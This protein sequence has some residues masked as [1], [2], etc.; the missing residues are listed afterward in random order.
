MDDIER[1]NK[2]R[3]CVQVMVEDLF[4]EEFALWQAR[5]VTSRMTASKGSIFVL[6]KMSADMRPM[7]VDAFEVIDIDLTTM[8]GLRVWVESK[9]FAR[10]GYAITHKPSQLAGDQEVFAWVPF[11]PNV[12]YMPHPGGKGWVLRAEICA[13]TRSRSQDPVAGD[14]YLSPVGEFRARFRAFAEVRF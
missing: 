11:I 6:W 10:L 3:E 2:E 1:K 5:P 8:E 7:I 12:N 4:V 14:T 9:R 13:R